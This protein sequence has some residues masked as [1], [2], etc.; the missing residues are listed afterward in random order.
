MEESTESCELF[1]NNKNDFPPKS[2][3]VLQHCV[4]DKLKV[5]RPDPSSNQVYAEWRKDAFGPFER[6]RDDSV[7]FGA[8]KSNDRVVVR[9]VT[10][11]GTCHHGSVTP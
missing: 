8:S 11:R 9:C 7:S 10:T 3:K 1:S 6:S 4:L 5:R 2:G